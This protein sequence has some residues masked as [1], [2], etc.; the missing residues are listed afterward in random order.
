LLCKIQTSKS[1]S[2]IYKSLNSLLC[3]KKER[4]LFG[5]ADYAR[6]TR[7]ADP[8]KKNSRQRTEGK[9]VQKDEERSMDSVGGSYSKWH[10]L[11]AITKNNTVAL[12][13][14]EAQCTLSILSMESPETI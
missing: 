8:Y 4:G 13:L 9:I 14:S 6:V 1:F 5:Q 7:E 11:D 10:C 2:Y 3:S 12:F